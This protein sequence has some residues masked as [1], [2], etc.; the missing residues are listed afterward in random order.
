MW[1]SHRPNPK[2][3]DKIGLTV[4]T[5]AGAGLGH[6]TKTMR[7]SLFFWGVKK[8]F[9][10]KKPV[11]AM[12]WSEVSEK[13]QVKIKKEAVKLAAR[14]L[15]A[16]N[17]VHKL[18]NPPLRSIFFNLMAGAQKKNDWNA[19]DKNHWEENGWLSGGKPF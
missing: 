12:K 18:P 7:N 15:K 10:L 8:S 9:S 1:I 17:T 5:T 3:F 19:T 11:A 4:A 16:A 6:T 13:N 14:I 2:M